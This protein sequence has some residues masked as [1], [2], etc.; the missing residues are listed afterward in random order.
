MHATRALQLQRRTPRYHH[1]LVLTLLAFILSSGCGQD[2][3]NTTPPAIKVSPNIL[4]FGQTRLLDITQETITLENTGG[5][6]LELRGVLDTNALAAGFQLEN[7]IQS[8]LAPNTAQDLQISFSPT[9]LGPATGKLFIESNDPRRPMVW[10]ELHGEG[11]GGSLCDLPEE[12]E[13]GEVAVGSSKVLTIDLE[14]CGTDTLTITSN[15]SSMGDFALLEEA[16][17]EIAPGQQIQVEVAFAPEA[18]GFQ[19][20]TL[21]L[22]N[23]QENQAREIILSGTGITPTP[24]I[25]TIPSASMDFGTVLIHESR[26]LPFTLKN[27]G[28][29][30][31][32]LIQ[33]A[34]AN[35]DGTFSSDS[36]INAAPVTLEIG[37]SLTFNL[38][39]TPD[40]VGAYIDKL[41]LF[42]AY[43]SPL[44][45]NIIG[46]G[47]YGYLC[48]S[49]G[50]VHFGNVIISHQASQ[51]IVIS[52]CGE[53]EVALNDIAWTAGTSPVYMPQDLT[54][55]YPTSLS[56]GESFTLNIAVTPEFQGNLSGSISIASAQTSSHLEIPVSTQAIAP[57]MCLLAA[58]SVL[59]FGPI[60]VGDSTIRNLQLTNCSEDALT[61]TSLSMDSSASPHF[62]IASETAFPIE[63]E[64]GAS[65]IVD[66]NFMAL[67]QGIHENSL[68]VTNI[69]GAEA[70][71]DILARAVYPQ[72][73]AEPAQLSFGSTTLG[74]PEM[75]TLTLNNCG[76]VPFTLSQAQVLGGSGSPFN[77]VAPSGLPRTLAP[78]ASH[79]MVVYFFPTSLGPHTDTLELSSDDFLTPPQVGLSG[80]G[81]SADTCWEFS[82]TPAELDFGLIYAGTES[83]EQSEYLLNCGDWALEI[84]GV[85]IVG[86]GAEHFTLSTPPFPLPNP[87]GADSS[88]HF[89]VKFTPQSIGIFTGFAKI[90]NTADVD[91][92]IPLYGEAV[93]PE[94]CIL[95]PEYGTPLDFGQVNVFASRNESLIVKNCGQ[96]PLTLSQRQL[97]SDVEGIFSF[98]EPANF[99]YILTPDSSIEMPMR[100]APNNAQL[101]SAE[102]NLNVD[103]RSAPYTIELNGTGVLP[104]VCLNINPSSLN[105]GI[106]DNGTPM[107][108]E[109]GITNCSGEAQN[110]ELSH[111]EISGVD[112]DMF[113]VT[114][115]SQALPHSLTPGAETVFEVEFAATNAGTFN[116]I[117]EIY[118]TSEQL[119]AEVPLH[120]VADFLCI[121]STPDCCG[122]GCEEDWQVLINGGF[123][124][125]HEENGQLRPD[126]W[127]VLIEEPEQAT[128]QVFANDD[129]RDYVLDIDRVD[130]Y[131]EGDLDRVWQ[132]LNINVTHCGA[133][134][135][136]IDGKVIY[137]S[138]SGAGW[139]FGEWPLY[140]R[141]Y[142]KDASGQT[143][144]WV[145]GFYYKG[146]VV[147]NWAPYSIQVEQD[148][149]FHFIS[150]NLLELEYPPTT[151]TQLVVGG[152]GWS[153]KSKLDSVKLSGLNPLCNP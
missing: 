43:G 50:E 13:F 48:A 116:G 84:T 20:H 75:Q 153:Y 14:N 18:L 78:A 71:V 23:P 37:E 16:G 3:L 99:P 137:Q 42:D 97:S 7:E 77:V 151:I 105:F 36:T 127:T 15:L 114:Q 107:P 45:T 39:F 142:Y 38:T 33:L 59:D 136:E 68:R 95:A 29:A 85:E 80:T 55:L 32:S 132:N 9:L 27:C 112:S 65:T 1:S 89:G 66:I 134:H 101:F 56:S 141:L 133:L 2:T 104:A 79:S 123:E 73:C 91:I 63:L 60:K 147:A 83:Y 86:E 126:D 53:I 17:L 120:A 148:T 26:T 64:S 135:V 96:L 51:S 57:P 125:T 76:E 146:S 130:P 115:A 117:L 111:V 30:P 41:I 25:E 121:P 22:L 92:R 143:R 106:V 145:R 108:K 128:I 109:V 5:S 4:D 87:I 72:L 61:L 24:C 19:S 47:D 35:N 129:G 52:N 139:A 98:M 122:A 10:V 11:M 119:L 149:W 88:A 100:F 90:L 12:L 93:E 138:L 70:S 110:I 81:T 74:Q 118:D 94:L 131:S 144:Q 49:P 152:A 58:P 6:E 31:L 113:T 8:S 150:D 34:F 82:S 54:G 69:F 67:T 140:V 124:H 28:D 44:M 46:R 62:S 102:V 21:S 103:H 40:T